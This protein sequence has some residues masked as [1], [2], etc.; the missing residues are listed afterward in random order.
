MPQRYPRLEDAFL[1]VEKL[2][3]KRAFLIDCVN[4]KVIPEGLKLD[5]NLCFSTNNFGLYSDIKH[6]LSKSSSTLLDTLIKEINVCLRDALD[7]LSTFDDGSYFYRECIEN[8]KW[9]N[10]YHLISVKDSHRRKLSYLISESYG[11]DNFIPRDSLRVE[12]KG[13]ISQ[14]ASAPY[15]KKPRPSRRASKRKNNRIRK[16]SLFTPTEEDRALFDPIILTDRVT[17]TED[18]K[19]ICRL[20]DCFAPTPKEP[21]DIPDLMLSFLK[22]ANQLRWQQ[23]HFYQ[24]KRDPDKYKDKKE[25]IKYPWTQPSKKEAPKGDAALENFIE[26]CSRDIIDPSQR[27]VIKDNLTPGQRTALK[28]LRLLPATHGVA[29]RYADKAGVTVITNIE[30]D[31]ELILKT[32]DDENHYDRLQTDPTPSITP[33]VE[34]WATKYGLNEAI[35]DEIID[36]VTNLEDTHPGECKPLF[37]THKPKP[38]PIRLLLSGCGTPIAPLS[39]FVQIGISHITP[40]LDYQVID[41]KEFLKKIWD[42]NRTM[43]PLPEGTTLVT[44]DVV[45]LYPNVNNEMG[46]PAVREKL[47]EYPSP[48]GFTTDSIVEA[49]QITLDNNVTRYKKPDGETIYARPNHGTAMGP[50]HACDYVDIF[51]N[52]IDEAFI[53]TCPFPLLSSLNPTNPDKKLDW[54]RFRDDGFLVLPDTNHLEDLETHLQSLHPPNIKWTLNHGDN[55]EYLD[56][57]L[58]LKDGYIET[59]VFSKNCHSYLP[60][61]SCHPPSV[62]KGLFGGMGNR[63]RMICSTQEKLDKR[64]DEYSKYLAIS[65][66]PFQKAKHLLTKATTANRDDILLKPRK[67]K[68]KKTAWVSKYD[69]RL[70]DKSKIIHKNIHLLYSNTDNKLVFPPGNLISA[71]RK[72][73]N[74]REIYKPTVPRLDLEHGPR[75]KPGFTTCRGVCDT[76]KHSK[77]TT[78]VKSSWDQRKWYIRDQITCT[79]K[80]VIYLIRCKLHPEEVYIGSA[81]DLKDR[82]RCHK[83]DCKL[84]KVKKCSMARHVNATPHPEITRNGGAPFLEIVPIEAVSDESRLLSRESW[85]MCNFGSIFDKGLNHRKDFESMNRFKNRIQYNQE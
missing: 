67:N 25:F 69:P 57:K 27:R 11:P 31:C 10:H 45:T 65:G 71:N 7:V 53:E 9:V 55:L 78:F 82:W 23:F 51:M 46:V 61:D 22:W 32:I 59:D 38:F 47:E 18:Q 35:S 21:I 29:C 56:I 85:W 70:P 73:K 4:N 2:R 76:C 66:W 12:A 54:S 72:R 20:P 19:Y 75:R 1:R 80:N 6:I 79:T 49:L 52:V 83:S 28:E 39:K 5:F 60:P 63:L 30:D 42:I 62:F 33:I 15:Q 17:L 48:L 50:A 40:N 24:Q 16:A 44:C 77:D 13:Y 14:K 37:K 41:S 81:I 8:I 43:A 68:G 64:V 26:T 74:L 36:Y 84:K 34:N 3:L 58:S